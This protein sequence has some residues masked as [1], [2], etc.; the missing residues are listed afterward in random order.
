MAVGAKG[1]DILLQFLIEALVLTVA[2]GVMGMALGTGAAKV[3]ASAMEWP[4]LLGWQSYTLGFGFS[5]T[6]G[7]LFGFYPAWRASRLDPIEALRFE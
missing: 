3:L 6:V 7:V 2:G 4:A 1:Q 5:A